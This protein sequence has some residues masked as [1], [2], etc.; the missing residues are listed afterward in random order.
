MVD[1][2][3]MAL[4]GKQPY[5]L[6]KGLK[7]SRKLAALLIL[8]VHSSTV[9]I[10]KLDTRTE[11]RETMPECCANTSRR[12][13]LAPLHPLLPDLITSPVSCRL[14]IPAPTFLFQ[15]SSAP[16]HASY[17]LC[18]PL[19]SLHVNK[20]HWG[21][22]PHFRQPHSRCTHMTNEINKNPN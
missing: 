9:S 5:E 17:Y 15:T 20:P 18:I 22:N 10:A 13:C 4:V 8:T 1:D 19:S 6:P 3:S 12:R 16:F 7:M 2:T 14:H 11:G 21:I